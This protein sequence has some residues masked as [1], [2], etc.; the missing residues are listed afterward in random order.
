MRFTDSRAHRRQTNGFTLIEL[1]V[2]I[3]IIALLIA[4]L[5]PALTGAREAANR[6]QCANN[7]KQMAVSLYAYDQDYKHL[8]PGRY[9]IQNYVG[10]S[11][12]TYV[13]SIL[14]DQ[15]GVALEMTLCPSNDGWDAAQTSYVWDKDVNSL[16]RLM[17]W[18]FAGWGGRG[19]STSNVKDGVVDMGWLGSTFPEWK[20]GFGPIATLSRVT[21]GRAGMSERFLMFDIAYEVSPHN[22][23]PNYGS[24]TGGDRVVGSNALFADG[25]VEWH[26][27]ISGVSWAASPNHYWTPT[28]EPY[29]T[30]SYY[31]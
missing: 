6:L 2:V 26:P 7:L 9:N 30:V 20:D 16:G 31:P 5:L 22:Q 14:R 24:H 4:L 29:G 1:L 19:A 13:H 12:N 28:F 18:Y 8:P 15:Y 3:S 27:L 23:M 21:E 10:N 17:Y 11:S 25:H